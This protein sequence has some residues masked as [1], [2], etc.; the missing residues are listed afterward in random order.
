MLKNAAIIEKLTLEQKAALMSGQG[1]WKSYAVNNQVPAMFLSDGPLGLRKQSGAGDHLGLNGSEPAT[2]FP[3][4][5]TLANSWDLEVVE[6][7]GK[8]LGKEAQALDVHQVLG[9]GLNIKRNP[10]GGRNFEYYSEDPYLAGKLAGRVIRGIQANGT[11]AT[12]KHFAV[13]SQETRRMASNSVVDE[14]TLREIYLTNFEIAIQ[15][16]HPKSI[17]TSYNEVNGTYTNE[18]RHLLQ[19]ILRQEFGF[20]G[21]VVTD[22][23]GDND[24]IAGIENGSNL[25]MPGLKQPG[26]REVIAA[27]QEGRLDEAV[28]NQRVDEL[29]NVVLSSNA[30]KK[31]DAIKVDWDHQH[32]VAYQA[33]LKSIVLLKNEADVLPL[34][35]E[36]RVALIGDFAANPRYQ[37]AGS[38]LVNTKNLET[39]KDTAQAHGVTLAGYAQGYKRVGQSDSTLIA[40]AKDLAIKSDVVV[41]NVGLNEVSES[42]GM[43]RKNMTMPANQVELI[44][45][46]SQLDQKLVVV[47]SAGSPVEMPWL[48][49]VDAVVHGYLGGEAGAGAMWEVLTGAY[50][51]SGRLAETYPMSY[52]DVPFGEE[53]PAHRRNS[54]YKESL[55]V[56]YRYYD[57]A[58]K[59]VR[60]PFG[61][62]LSY[63]SF[64]YDNL[65]VNDQGVEVKVTNTGQV[66]G[67][68]TVQLY[69]GKAETNVLRPAK[70]L[71]GFA[72]VSLAPGESQQVKI[73]FDDKTF[74]YFDVTSDAWQV[75]AGTYQIMIGKNVNDIVLTVDYQVEGQE[76]VASQDEVFAKYQACDLQNISQNDFENYFNLEFKQNT[77]VKGQNLG[78]NDTLAE[79]IYAKSWIARAVAK[80][81]K[82][83]IAKS[84]AKGK[85]DL[86]LLFNYNM[87]FRAMGKMTGGL[88]DQDMVTAILRIVNGHF[89]SGSSRLIKGYFRNQK[90]NKADTWY[91]EDK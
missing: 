26:A 65:S 52:A 23:G 51:P 47:L 50:N 60:F 87:P 42:E 27:V 59:A 40:E 84:E 18:S 45:E 86:N 9:P 35:Q 25:V 1:E 85:P 54:Y 22:W 77:M 31:N 57:K 39:L 24:H 72:Q 61:F 63:T 73:S 43:D 28:L 3:S 83:A 62:G 16:G 14:R 33:A 82:N 49:Q 30:T 64:T 37:G 69:I 70:E 10:L 44:Q 38:S 2:C 55:F 6:A 89:W 15:E 32:Q 76:A 19:D 34:T 68:E 29:L 41:L 91:E 79:M 53:F 20:D 78:Y 66:A 56:G 80:W 7:V 90:R 11:I 71:K 12:P 88:I 5:A 75:E 8:A 48:D 36:T 74:R 21:Y 13:N 17:M 58:Q 4:S 46:L 81:L 67:V